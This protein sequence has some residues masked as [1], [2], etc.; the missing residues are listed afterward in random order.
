[1]PNHQIVNCD[2]P[3]AELAGCVSPDAAGEDKS[4]RSTGMTEAAMLAIERL[5]QAYDAAFACARDAWD[6][7]IELKQMKISG[8]DTH[9]L[10]ILISKNLITHRRETTRAQECNRT[11][12][13]VGGL[14]LSDQSCFVISK[15][16]YEFA[17]SAQSGQ[18]AQTKPKEIKKP[19]TVYERKMMSLHHSGP[20][21]GSQ[22][23]NEADSNQLGSSAYPHLQVKPA[24]D[25]ENRELRLGDVVVKRF[26]WPAENQELV[27]DAFQELGWPARVGNPLA[28]HPNICP[29]VRLH[30]TLK[31]L[32]RKQVNELVKFRGDGTGL[33]IL[34]E[35][36]TPE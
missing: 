30:D 15:K 18:R 32:N 6:F 12:E 7:S 34:L 16:G 14:A 21:A 5:R 19:I 11:F 20:L 4:A 29:K 35:I 22:K 24:G 1:M 25:R 10:R 27:L 28:E 13:S 2:R 33:G 26:R 8:I 36:R 9:V 17:K 23:I 3:E 31:C